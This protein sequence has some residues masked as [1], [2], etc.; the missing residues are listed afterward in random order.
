[1]D[2]RMKKKIDLVLERVKDPESNLSVAD[3]GLVK[4]LRYS[5]EKK[6]LYVFTDFFSRHPGCLTCAAVASLV[7]S[8]I[9]KNLDKEFKK[10]FPELTI[11]FI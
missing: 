4:R 5:E 2:E 10:E 7:V 1:M 8:D 11:E 6:H 3:L 9:Q